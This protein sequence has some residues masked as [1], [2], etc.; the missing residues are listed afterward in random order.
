MAGDAGDMMSPE[1]ELDAEG[2]RTGRT[3]ATQFQRT[4][5]YQAIPPSKRLTMPW[6]TQA[7]KEGEK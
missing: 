1:H 2:R 6:T 3:R 7:K 4:L 5:R